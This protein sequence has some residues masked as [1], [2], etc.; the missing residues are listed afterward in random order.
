MNTITPARVRIPVSGPFDLSEV[1]KM[2]FGHRDVRA[3]DGV[4]RLAFCLDDGSGQ[5]GVEVRQDGAEVDLTIVPGPGV[6]PDTGEVAAQVARVISADHDGQ[7]YAEICQAD[8]VLKRV[9]RVAPGFR[10]ANFYSPYEGAVWSVLSA[11]RSRQQAIPVRDR[12]GREYGATFELAG[13]TVTAS[14]TPRQLRT[15]TSVQGLPADRIPRLHAIAEAA[16][17]GD[18]AVERLNAMAPDEAKAELQKLPGIGPFYS[19]LI[20]I[21]SSGRADVLPDEAHVR[22]VVAKFYGRDFSDQE[23]ADLAE[24]WRPFRT[25]VGVM[26]RA[27]GGRLE[28]QEGAN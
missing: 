1:A 12:L 23:F 4:M 15:V 21:R 5:V 17:R 3:F 20:V 2:G 9:W 8:P 16:E 11:R 22:E 7:V 18:L 27:L 28:S 10:P 24:G 26:L 6:D 14:P 25:W 19:A 13:Q